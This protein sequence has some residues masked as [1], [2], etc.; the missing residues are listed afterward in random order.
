[1]NI[2]PISAD[3]FYLPNIKNKNSILTFRAKKPLYC[4]IFINQAKE[5]KNN[6][7]FDDSYEKLKSEA[8]EYILNSK[9]ITRFGLFE[10]LEKYCPD[11][12]LSGCTEKEA[13]HSIVMAQYINAPRMEVKNGIAKIVDVHKE[14]QINIPDDLDDNSRLNLLLRFI[15]ESTHMLQNE[16]NDRTGWA[17]IIERFIENIKTPRE[18]YKKVKAIE[19]LDNR[20]FAFENCIFEI[21]EF[22]LNNYEV[23]DIN[24]SNLNKDMQDIHGLKFDEAIKVIVDEVFYKNASNIS[25]SIGRKNLAEYIKYKLANELEAYKKEYET[26]KEFKADDKTNI[27]LSVII[28]VLDETIE[29]MDK[30]IKNKRF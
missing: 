1:M 14:M 27:P 20:F 5:N 8:V 28:T 12:Y 29:A 26:A 15:H 6:K 17:D 30:L 16:S 13:E 19:D 11:I 3:K 21:I 22:A 2:S 23:D 7:T 25:R 10:I 24:I 9:E 18:L 4:D